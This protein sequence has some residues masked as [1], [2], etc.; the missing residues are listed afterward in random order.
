MKGKGETI[1]HAENKILFIVLWF[2]ALGVAL[3]LPIQAMGAEPSKV[4]KLDEIVVRGQADKISPPPSSATIITSEEIKEFNIK[5]PLYLLESVPGVVIQDYCQGQ[6]ASQ[7][8]MRGLR[9][10]HNVGAALFVD[11]V[12]INE[13]T[14]HGDGYA[15]YNVVIPEDIDY[16]EVIK[17]PSSALYGQFARAGVINIVT[18]R[19]G[20]FNQ[21]KLGGGSWGTQ[22]FAMSAG[23]SDGGSHKVFGA[24]IYHRDGKTENSKWL[25]ANATGKFTKDFSQKLTGS[26]ALNFNGSE[27]DA[28]EYISRNQWDAG[29]YWSGKPLSG[30]EKFR[31]G[32]SANLTY[33]VTDD[34]FLNGMV[35]Y[36]THKF[37]RYRDR[38][39]VT[40]TNQ[41]GAQ[42]ESYDRQIVGGSFSYVWNTK[43]GGMD[44][45]LTVGVDGQREY[46]GTETY[47]NPSLVR[48]AREAPTAN[49]DSII[50]TWSVFFQNR[51]QP[52]KAWAVTLGCRYDR[53]SGE[54]KNNLT[55]VDTDAEDQDIFSPKFG[56]EFTP[57]AG[58]TLFTTYG[59]GFMLPYGSDK[60]NFPQLSPETFK[61]YE[62]G[63]KINP[64]ERFHGVLSFFVLD[65]E[66][67]IV[68]DAANG[69]KQNQGKTRRQGVELELKYFPL[70]DLKL[71][72]LASYTKGEYEDYINNGV[73]YNGTDIEGVPDWLYSFGVKWQP[74]EGLFGGFDARYVGPALIQSYAADFAGTK[75][76]TMDYWVCGAQLGYRLGIY[77]LT[78]DVTN[79]FDERYPAYE[80]ADSLRTANP[81]GA[82]L[83][84]AVEY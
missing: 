39:P 67:E 79:I 33:D 28:P 60:F 48:T 1:M 19:R 14:S 66:D 46:G 43:L 78:L 18:K 42:E 64:L 77:S 45:S 17:G 68:T 61:Q 70:D 73:N 31:F 41:R 8:I 20:N 69:T 54:L 52:S 35:Y 74:R 29:D 23:R 59:E 65:I 51:L 71:Y 49:G 30:G 44:N 9:L 13:S 3:S 27:W 6:T 81:M 11:G 83:T 56:L 25:K 50:D 80:T 53:M 34:S 76:E 75:V 38:T 47:D 82:F 63:L 2:S 58:Y 7:F 72:A 10:G 22:R 12:P 32:G 57:V 24:E 40:A 84:F 15:D 5:K 16:V 37:T 62:I 4:L 55:G 36:Y 21:Y 26:I